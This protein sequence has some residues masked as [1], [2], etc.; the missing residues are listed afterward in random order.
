MTLQAAEFLKKLRELDKAY[1]KL[2]RSIPSV[3][4]AEERAN[5]TF[6]LV[7][8]AL[9]D[10][11]LRNQLDTL[12]SDASDDL[13]S[14]TNKVVSS[15]EK[16][17]ATVLRE[18]ASDVSEFGIKRSELNQIF[19]EFIE[20][21]DEV[22]DFVDTVSDLEAV[23]KKTHRSIIESNRISLE[24]PRKTKKGRRR[25]LTQGAFNVLA[26]T[27][28]IVANTKFPPS[29]V[30]SYALGGSALLEGTRNFIGKIPDQ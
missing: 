26:G 22:C 14:Q 21:E 9:Q 7:M 19:K 25:D 15:V 2:T 12:L 11:I 29:F 1:K 17:K 27:A 10:P 4:I 23:L 18:E 3:K 24:L 28:I 8:M 20:N 16:R 30:V 6:D 13:E 5:A